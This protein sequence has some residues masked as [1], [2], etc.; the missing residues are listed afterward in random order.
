MIRRAI[1][2]V[3]FASALSVGGLLALATTVRE[4]VEGSG[5]SATEE[6]D[7]GNV[8]EVV[9]SGVGDLTIVP[10]AMPALSVTADDN[11]L[12]ALET[13]AS[14]GKLHIG[15]RSLTS[16]HPKTKIHYT[17]TVPQLN[18]I[19]VSGAGTVKTQRLEADDLKLKLSGAG[20]V[21]LD[22]LNCKSLAITLS[23]SGIANLSGPAEH[24]KLRLSGAGKIDAVKLQTN[25]ADVRI[26]G[27]GQAA[28]WSTDELKARISGAGNV[29]YRGQPQ[30]IEQK[31]SGSG[32]IRALE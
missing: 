9:L 1:K 22:N 7:I 27:A 28:I 4:T 20:K 5:I 18:S 23:G 3:L 26:S 13:N 12:P 32:H 17:L 16:I 19:T 14:G 24:F 10:G 30:H 25:S 2:L 11:I 21:Q 6:R 15:T 29:K 8:N 31:V